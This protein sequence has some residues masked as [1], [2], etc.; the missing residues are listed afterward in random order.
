[1]GGEKVFRTFLGITINF[2][3]NALEHKTIGLC[4]VSCSVGP[5]GSIE[6]NEIV[7]PISSAIDEEVVRAIKLSEQYWIPSENE[8]TE[9]FY[10]QV[11]FRMDGIPNEINCPNV[12]NM[13]QV[14]EIEVVGISRESV[15][16]G[17]RT[18]DVSS[19]TAGSGIKTNKEIANLI[20]SSIKKEKYKKAKRYLDE[21]IRRNP[22]EISLYQLRSMVNTKLNEEAEA[23]KDINK[24]ANFMNDRSLLEIMGSVAK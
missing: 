23:M 21:A 10:V 7:N 11:L 22:Y 18:V 4:I 20:S 24:M 12:D 17:S 14:I 15:T 9:K 19:S 2:P 3:I 5:E 8:I 6:V 16:I 13:I 1:M